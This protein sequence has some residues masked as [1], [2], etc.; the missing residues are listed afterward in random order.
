MDIK[1]T[2]NT[3]KSLYMSDN[4]LNM[5]IDFER[6]L[7]NADLYVFPN[8]TKGELVEGPKISKYFVS[9]T[10]MWPES[11]MPDP[12]GAERLLSFGV[13]IRYKKT[14][15][16]M[17]VEIKQ[18]SDYRD[19]SHKGKLVDRTVWLVEILMPKNLMKDIKQ[20]SKEIAGTEID[21]SDLESAYEKGLDNEALK[22]NAQQ[23]PA[24]GAP[25]NV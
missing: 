11:K 8:W 20:G 1:Q 4:A 25:T 21:L 9:C 14:S 10:F 13:K 24:Q 22:D 3:I 7:D 6:V 18:P 19:G 2:L 5:L 17:P 16:K 23:A 12:S 15:I